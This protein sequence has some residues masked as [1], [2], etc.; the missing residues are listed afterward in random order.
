M[1]AR[2]KNHDLTEIYL[3]MFNL[4]ELQHKISTEKIME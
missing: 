4:H 3:E 2:V 1:F